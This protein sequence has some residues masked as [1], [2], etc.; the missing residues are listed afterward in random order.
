[1]RALILA[2]GFGS[3][4]RPLT[5]VTPKPLLEVGGQPMITFALD[6][7]RRAGIT[8]VVV[9][10]HHLGDQIRAALGDGSRY[11]LRIEYSPEDPIQDTGGAVA[12]ARRFLG[13]QPFVI[14]NSDIFVDLDLAAMLD[15]H[16]ERG[17]IATLLVRPDPE[18]L[19]RDDVGLD[20]HGRLLR[21]LDHGPRT[22][23]EGKPLAR[24][25]YAGVMVCEPTLFEYLPPG[26]YSLTRD[27]L[28]HVLAAGEAVFGYVHQGLWQVLDT[29]EDLAAGRLRMER[30]N[31]AGK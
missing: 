27:G 13:E 9:N 11:G 29:P 15:F 17:G 8:E 22:D 2:A 30:R 12:A 28:P 23:G 26:I 14:V 10:L 25:M 4:L 7:L 5:D 24:H 16:A 3:R 21:I 19:R 1:M 31:F 18:A 20:R 6:L